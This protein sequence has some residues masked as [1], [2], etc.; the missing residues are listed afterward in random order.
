MILRNTC[1]LPGLFGGL[2]FGR[3][4]LLLGVEITTRIVFNAKEQAIKEITVPVMPYFMFQ[5]TPNDACLG[6][7]CFKRFGIFRS[8]SSVRK[9][10]SPMPGR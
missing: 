6:A 7:S 3:S 8:Y 1:L 2:I 4:A 10:R 9:S 5:A